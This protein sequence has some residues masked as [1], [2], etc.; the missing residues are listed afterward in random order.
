MHIR[1]SP[2]RRLAH[3]RCSAVIDDEHAVSTAMLGPWKFITLDTR[4]ATDQYGE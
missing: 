3:A 1:L 4:F 2:L